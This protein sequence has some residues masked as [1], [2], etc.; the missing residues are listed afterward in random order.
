VQ[1]GHFALE[2][3]AEARRTE[4]GCGAANG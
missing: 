4:K 2:F 1:A 3:H